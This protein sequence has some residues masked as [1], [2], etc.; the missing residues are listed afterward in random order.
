MKKNYLL[1]FL[2]RVVIALTLML[3]LSSIAQPVFIDFPSN[4]TGVVQNPQD[5]IAANGS[6]LLRV[7][8]TMYATSTTG[9]SVTVQLPVG[10][11]YVS[12]SVA[13]ISSVSA[14]SLSISEDGGTTNA[15]KFKIGTAVVAGQVIEFTIL[16]KV[17]CKP[18]VN[19][20]LK[21]S[22]TFSIGTASTTKESGTTYK[23]VEPVLTFVNPTTQTNAVVGQTY[24]RTFKLINGGDG[25]LSQIHFTIDYPNGGIEN[26]LAN[27]SVSLTGGG[28]AT[29]TPVVLL[30]TSNVGT[31]YFY[32]VPSTAL[33]GGVLTKK[34]WC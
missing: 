8:L 16:R 10:V 13:K 25:S 31:K 11:E 21:D 27:K 3:G 26:S 30:P 7:Q 23:V 15:P 32:T 6:S 12:G 24:T 14:A 9:A 5:V 33:A 1:K 2:Q 4:T 19:V 18:T 28:G 17:N 20:G 29:G 22:V 34:H